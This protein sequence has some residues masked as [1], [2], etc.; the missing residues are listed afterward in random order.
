MPGHDPGKKKPNLPT[1]PRGV[2]TPAVLDSLFSMLS[3]GNRPTLSVP[4]LEDYRRFGTISPAFV[5]IPPDR[6]MPQGA[7][8]TT[9]RGWTRNRETRP[10]IF[11]RQSKMDPVS[12]MA[13]EVGHVLY[14][15][16]ELGDLSGTDEQQIADEVARAFGVLSGR[17]GSGLTYER[18]GPELP[19]KDKRTIL[20]RVKELLN[21][22]GR[23]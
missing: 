1:G 3:G 23:D 8:R 7:K 14:Q 22:L 6:Y 5:N 13:H 2:L 16:G 20:T 21:N 4:E 9:E 15:K 11:Y 12:V 17:G 19:L 18:S 10:E